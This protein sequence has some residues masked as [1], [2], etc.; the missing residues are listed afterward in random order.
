[1]GRSVDAAILAAALL[2]GLALGFTAR[3]PGSS[4]GALPLSVSSSRLVMTASEE[5]GAWV[6]IAS[7]S[8]LEKIQPVQI[9]VLGEKLVVWGST[10]DKCDFNVLQDADV[11]M[12]VEV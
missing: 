5:N 8:A 10:S 11:E 3:L 9:E 4:R 7:A 2:S 12:T 1:M 6:P